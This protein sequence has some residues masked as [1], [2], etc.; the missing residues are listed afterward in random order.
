MGQKPPR[1]PPVLE[2]SHLDTMKYGIDVHVFWQAFEG[3][4]A[5]IL[6]AQP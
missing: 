2:P 5:S 3:M 6:K 1:E 4:T